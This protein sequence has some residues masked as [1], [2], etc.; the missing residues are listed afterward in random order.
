MD[1]FFT[2]MVWFLNALIK[3]QLSL[4]SSSIQLLILVE[5][6]AKTAQ[7]LAQVMV[8]NVFLVTPVFL[9]YMRFIV[10][11]NVPEDPILKEIIAYN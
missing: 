7:I 2:N 10:L 5:F 4:I 11:A 1:L 8:Y 6:N 3:H 9:S